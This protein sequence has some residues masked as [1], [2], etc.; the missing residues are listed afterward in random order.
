M[1]KHL[2]L[3]LVSR[4]TKGQSN[5]TTVD[6]EAIWTNVWGDMQRYGPVHRHHRRIFSDMIG[7]VP[8]EQ[9][10]TVADF[11]CG[12]GFVPLLARRVP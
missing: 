5:M 7:K 2:Y 6:Y 10:A 8:R 4:Q 9:I 12:E 3:P 11:G 1:V